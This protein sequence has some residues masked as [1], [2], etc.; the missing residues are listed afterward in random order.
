[1]IFDKLTT[2]ENQVA[3]LALDCLANK[4]IAAKLNISERTVK[5]HM[6]CIY[7]RLGF[8]I[9]SNNSN[10]A[11]TKLVQMLSK[12]AGTL[13]ACLI[14]S[15][16]AHAQAHSATLTWSQPQ[17]PSGVTVTNV[18]VQKD[19]TT[20]TN[21]TPATLSYV[22]NAVTAGQTYAY[23]VTNTF[24]D[25]TTTSATASATIPAD[26]P[27]PPPSCS[28]IVVG[29]RVSV[30]ANANI[31][32]TAVNNG[33]GALL[34]VEPAGTLGT[35]TIVSTAAVPNCTGCVW[36]QVQFDTAPATIPNRTGYMG[37]DNMTLVNTA[38]VVTVAIAPASV[39]ILT[40]ATQQFTA[41]VTGN[42]NTAVTWSANAPGGLFTAGASAGTAT[43][44][45]TSVADPTKSASAVVTVTLPPLAINCSTAK[46]GVANLTTG[47]YSMTVTQGTRTTS[48]TA[49]N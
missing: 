27:P 2:R 31:R 40:G 29:C 12:M 33:F 28:S 15:F 41:T 32:A 23:A 1:M 37:S 25:S 21:L 18:S 16:S 4:E 19:G 36:V 42:A 17:Q 11:R 44:I 10:T 8:E 46:A 45:A 24:N 14:L 3:K 49:V 35:I 47:N 48:C 7:R 22:D 38:P 26:V 34:G 13:A 6:Q 20:V 39:S 5:F 30:K 43:V 9:G